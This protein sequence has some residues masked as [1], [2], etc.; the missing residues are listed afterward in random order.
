[1]NN[2]INN[3]L[4]N[5]TLV[6]WNAEDWLLKFRVAE[7]YGYRDL[8][9]R[10][11]ENTRLIVEAGRYTLQDGRTIKLDKTGHLKASSKFYHHPFRPEFEALSTT[12][13]ITV[14]SD[15]C[16]DVA[17]QWVMNGMD[18]SLLNMASRRNPGGGVRNGAGAQEEYLFRCSNYYRFLYRYASY[19]EEYGLKKSHY[20]YPLDRNYGGIYTPSVTIFRGNEQSGY[21]LLEKPWQVNII[22]VAGMNSPRIV[23]E[24]GSERIARDLIAG[25]KNKI[26]T[27]FR[28]ACDQGQRNLVLGALGCGAFHNPPLHVAELFRDVLCEPEFW[29]AFQKVCFAVKTD[30]N[31][32]HSTNYDAFRKVLHHYILMPNKIE[33]TVATSF[34]K[35]IRKIEVARDCYALLYG[36]GSVSENNFSSGKR[37][38][39]PG[40]DNVIDIAAGYDH[41][42]GLRRD[43][44]IVTG[45][46]C[47]AAEHAQ[48]LDWSGGLLL[49]ACEAH[50]AMLMKNG[51]VVCAEDHGFEVENYKHIVESWKNLKQIVVT[52]YEP[53]G[54]TKQGKLISRNKIIEHILNCRDKKITEISAFSCYYSTVTVAALYDDGTVKAWCDSEIPE[55]STWR[56]VKKICCGN[57]GAVVGLTENGRVL[58]PDY[59][60]YVD[61]TGIDRKGLE[62]ISDIAVNYDHLVAVDHEENVI[63]LV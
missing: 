43:G 13:E 48:Y 35:R 42:L 33:T 45:G 24:N 36:D 37:S 55:V 51:T 21:P 20:Q 32:R 6:T 62:N 29:G 44:I 40:F 8:R 49:S 28:I 30:H 26:R 18:V 27:I 3:Y 5:N 52:F 54:L 39:I 1:M 61:L 50:S 2:N 22:A 12:P 38:L 23:Y 4:T 58:L 47:S 25:V 19:A 46:K 56:N 53:F 57:H 15:D 63:C 7:Q 16:L 9:K 10:V 34:E 31:S 17:H 41:I 14:V 60:E 11:W 59:I